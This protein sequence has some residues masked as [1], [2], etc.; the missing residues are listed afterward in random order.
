MRKL[1]LAFIVFTLLGV[2]CAKASVGDH[3]GKNQWSGR[4]MIVIASA[5]KHEMG[6]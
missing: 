4:R 2:L 3:P 1:L 6:P 5:I